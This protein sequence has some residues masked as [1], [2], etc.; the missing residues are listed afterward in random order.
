MKFKA[1]QNN[2]KS[3][4]PNTTNASTQTEIICEENENSVAQDKCVSNC[5]DNRDSVRKCNNFAN[6]NF[7]RV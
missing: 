1:Y 5:D 3:N 2:L 7:F 4:R 6:S